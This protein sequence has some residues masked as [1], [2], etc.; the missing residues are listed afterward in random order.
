MSFKELIRRIPILFYGAIRRRRSVCIAEWICENEI[1]GRPLRRLF[2][3]DGYVLYEY[4]CYA[5]HPT[6]F[7]DI[8]QRLARVNTAADLVL[9]FWYPLLSPSRGCHP[10]TKGTSFP[11]FIRSFHSIFHSS[12]SS[13]SSVLGA[14]PF[15]EPCF[16]TFFFMATAFP[17][18]Q[19][20]V[21][22]SAPVRLLMWLSP[23]NKMHQTPI[24]ANEPE[25][26]VAKMYE[27]CDVL[28]VAYLLYV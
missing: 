5:H 12:F 22:L 1:M 26:A 2:H 17:N 4:E 14:A 21:R 13:I 16:G 18:G 10:R 20:P 24:A 19:L 15:L 7:K 28:L 6:G 3:E 8:F 25:I 23:P 27:N 9:K 11:T